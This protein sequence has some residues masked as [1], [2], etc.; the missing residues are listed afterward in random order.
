MRTSYIFATNAI[1]AYI[2][3]L[4]LILL[5]EQTAA[6]YDIE[7]T[8]GGVY[9]AR[10]FGGALL[11][12]GLLTWLARHAVASHER[13]A[14]VLSLLLANGAGF[15]VSLLTQ[16]AGLTNA[17]GW[18]TII[19]YFVLSAGFAYVWLQSEPDILKPWLAR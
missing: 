13:R 18:I 16:L 5:P 3:G 6:I 1:V 10:L 8:D 11:S 2:F 7:L 9:I 4:A 17:L 15:V 14:I 12:L 19:L